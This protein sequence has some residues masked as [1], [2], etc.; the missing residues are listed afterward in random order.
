[1]HAGDG[2]FEIR[3]AKAEDI[4]ALRGLIEVSVRALQRADYSVEQLEAALGTAYGVDTQLIADR[5]YY[6]VE[7]LR[8]GDTRVLAACGGWSMRKTLYGSDHGPYRDNAMLDPTR[9]AAKIR[10]FFVHPEWTRRGLATLILKTCEDVAYARGFRRFEMGATLTGVPMYA[11]RG[12]AEIE[13]IEVPLP[14]GLTL[15][16][17]RMGKTFA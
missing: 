10:A 11:A 3:L 8:E 1:M 5:T 15:P 6:I 12:Y 2:Q 7:A 14:N 4:A 9:D 13:R 16:V 17:V